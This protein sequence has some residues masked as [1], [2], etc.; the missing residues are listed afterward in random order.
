MKTN[1]IV[2]TVSLNTQPLKDVVSLLMG[3]NAD[4]RIPEEVRK[5]YGDRILAIVN[6]K[7]RNRKPKQKKEEG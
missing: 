6:K 1:G 7:R 4:E 3:M 2:V 5:E